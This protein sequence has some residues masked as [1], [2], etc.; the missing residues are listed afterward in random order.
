MPFLKFQTYIKTLNYIVLL[1]CGKKITEQP[2]DINFKKYK[3][4][5]PHRNKFIKVF[6]I[7]EYQNPL[8]S[9][10]Q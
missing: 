5:I 6:G 3:S 1:F 10:P 8:A 9:G 7:F 2:Q 4:I